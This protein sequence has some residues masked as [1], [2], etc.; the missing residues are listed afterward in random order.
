MDRKVERAS[1]AFEKGGGMVV[2]VMSASLVVLP[3]GDDL[4]LSFLAPALRAMMDSWEELSERGGGFY[5]IRY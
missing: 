2:G 5:V 4:A 1:G 3:E